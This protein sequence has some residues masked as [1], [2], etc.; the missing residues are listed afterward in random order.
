MHYHTCNKYLEKVNILKREIDEIKYSAERDSP[1]V[2]IHCDRTLA[3]LEQ[4]KD[5]IRE[6]R[7]V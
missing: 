6:A 1:A 4:L 5:A 2:V 7:T 3:E